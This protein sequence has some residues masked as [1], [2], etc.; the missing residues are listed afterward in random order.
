MESSHGKEANSS[1]F[2]EQQETEPTT[3]STPGKMSCASAEAIARFRS[4]NMPE[5]LNCADHVTHSGTHVAEVVYTERT[6]L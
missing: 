3:P 6:A 2:N 4:F 5:E 1:G